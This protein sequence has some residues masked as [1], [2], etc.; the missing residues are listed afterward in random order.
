MAANIDEGKRACEAGSAADTREAYALPTLTVV[1]APTT[2]ATPAC[3][4]Q[5]HHP[6]NES[7]TTM[8]MYKNKGRH[9]TR[10]AITNLVVGS[11]LLA[12]I[13]V[14]PGPAQAG[15]APPRVVSE[16]EIQARIGERADQADADRLAIQSLLQREEVRSMAGSAGIDLERASAAAATLAGPTLETLAAQARAMDGELAGGD[17][18]IVLTTTGVII[19]LLILILL[20]N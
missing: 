17:G 8:N 6:D 18:T 5:A 4:E 12:S 3:Y 19:I 14:V 15:E 13:T 9:R 20:V 16:V 2:P 10:A 1:V 7:V 11:A